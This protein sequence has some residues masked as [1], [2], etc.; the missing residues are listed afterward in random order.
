MRF[1]NGTFKPHVDLE[2]RLARFHG[3][4]AAM[5]FSSAYATMI[6]TFPA[7]ISDATCL[8]SD[9]LNHNCIINAIR[10]SRP[11]VKEILQAPRHG[12]HGGADQEEHRRHQAG[13]HR[14]RRHLQHRRGD[15][16]P[17][18]KICEIAKKYDD[19]FPEGRHDHR[20]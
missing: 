3:R 7:L 6:G 9:E 12:R 2:K 17:L 4:E 8:V 20:R 13:G 1:I 18:D 19:Q 15:N 14:H 16:A 5:I 10:L 11:Q